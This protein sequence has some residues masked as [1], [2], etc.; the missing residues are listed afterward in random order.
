[1]SRSTGT[2]NFAANF[3]VLTK[4]PLDARLVVDTKANLTSP[5]IWEDTNNNVWLFKGIVVSVV[6][7]PSTSNNGLYFLTDETQYTDINYWLPIG[8]GVSV[9][10]SGTT[11]AT[12]QI[13]QDEQGVILRDSSGNLE[14]LSFDNSTYSSIKAGHIEGSS[15]K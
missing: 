2:F 3:E 9:D 5:E 7:D 6:S 12:F 14:I 13:N 15:L 8:V 1:M 11:W 4:A 10:A